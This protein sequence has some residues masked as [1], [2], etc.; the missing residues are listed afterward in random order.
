LAHE[1]NAPDFASE[2][3]KAGSDLDVV[4]ADKLLYG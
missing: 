4:I 1:A 2:G 3:A